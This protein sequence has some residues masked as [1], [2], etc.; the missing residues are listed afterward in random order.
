MAPGGVEAAPLGV[1]TIGVGNGSSC[2]VPWQ[3]GAVVSA[4]PSGTPSTKNVTPATARSSAALAVTATVPWSG[5]SPT[6]AVI[7][8]VGG[9]V[10]G[11]G[12]LKGLLVAVP[13]GVVT[14]IGP[15]VAPLGTVSCSA[16]AELTVKSA[17]TPLTVTTVAPVKFEPPIVT[18]VPAG[19][20]AGEKLVIVGDGIMGTV[21]M[22]ESTRRNM[23]R[24]AADTRR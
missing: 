4:A 19:P 11:S 2:V 12:T 16:V 1:Q 10:S 3:N 8:T 22:S 17:L 9:V 5:A 20:F 7:V 15:V 6:G 24:K 13:L 18:R 14:R 21:V 23:P